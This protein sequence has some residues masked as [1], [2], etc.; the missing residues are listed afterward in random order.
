MV[1]QWKLAHKL[2]KKV[3]ELSGL[4]AYLTVAAGDIS[5]DNKYHNK[6]AVRQILTTEFGN[7]DSFVDYF[8]EQ[9]NQALDLCDQLHEEFEYMK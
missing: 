6:E 7:E 3:N 1:N 5:L 2:N 8:T 9:V 4:I